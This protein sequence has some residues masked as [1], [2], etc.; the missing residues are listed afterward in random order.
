MSKDSLQIK[1]INGKTII[2]SEFWNTIASGL[3]N[4]R[5]KINLK[6]ESIK[7]FLDPESDHKDFLRIL[8]QQSYKRC[9]CYHLNARFDVNVALDI[10]GETSYTLQDNKEDDL[11]DIELLEEIAWLINQHYG[12]AIEIPN[13]MLS[14]MLS[15]DDPSEER[16]N[17]HDL[18]QLSSNKVSA[19]KA[20]SRKAGPV[21]S[22]SKLKIRRA[23]RKQ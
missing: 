22:M 2:F 1:K 10:L 7:Y 4:S 6:A 20:S 14:S 23:N 15:V 16:D 19:S 11:M 12:Q 8:I 9:R 5:F 13:S 18:C 17:E 3:G 21:I